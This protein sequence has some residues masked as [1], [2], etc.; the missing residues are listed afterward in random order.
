MDSFDESLEQKKSNSV[1][2]YLL[3]GF[4]SIYTFWIEGGN[5]LKLLYN[6]VA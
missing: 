6:H 3:N 1:T 5:T 4:Y 2:E